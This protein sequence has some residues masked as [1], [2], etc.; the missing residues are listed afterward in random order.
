MYSTKMKTWELIFEKQ[1]NLIWYTTEPDLIF[2]DLEAVAT[3][4]DPGLFELSDKKDTS[5]HNPRKNLEIFKTI[6]EL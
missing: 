1:R 2:L 6:S 3:W 4:A 5:V